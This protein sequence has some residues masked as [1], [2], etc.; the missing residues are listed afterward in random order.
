MLKSYTYHEHG[1]RFDCLINIIYY[2]GILLI[3]VNNNISNVG[4]Q[5]WGNC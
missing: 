3:D 2:I 4:S 5:L 1:V